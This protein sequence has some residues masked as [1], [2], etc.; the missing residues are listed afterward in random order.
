M[1]SSRNRTHVQTGGGGL[2]IGDG[3]TA[4]GV[5]SQV[6]HVS[7]GSPQAGGVN[8]GA[9]DTT[10]IA[11]KGSGH[12]LRAGRLRVIAGVLAVVAAAAPFAPWKKIFA[13]TPFELVTPQDGQAVDVRTEVR[14]TAPDSAAPVVVV[15]RA[16]QESRFWVQ[17]AAALA[18]D[19][20]WSVT[21]Y[22]GE[23]NTPTGTEFE[24]RAF[25]DPAVLPAP[26]EIQDWPRAAAISNGVRV[27]RR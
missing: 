18:S 20:S 5:G 6:V 13:P 9:T 22:L 4:S 15:V 3:A 17:P 23:E 21:A 7:V 19:G 27:E 2:A 11:A 10:P 14:G 26:G 1:S 24:I 16:V 25:R 8:G 12:E